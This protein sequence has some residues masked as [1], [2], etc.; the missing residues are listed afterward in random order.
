M[1]RTEAGIRAGKATIHTP[2]GTSVL[3]A[4]PTLSGVAGM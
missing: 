4:I 2:S 1:T 3:M